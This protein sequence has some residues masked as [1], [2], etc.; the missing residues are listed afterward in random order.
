MIATTLRSWRKRISASNAPTP[1]DGSVDR[2][3]I[4]WIKLSYKTPS[5]MYTV[6]SAARISNG[7]LDSEF[8]KDAAVP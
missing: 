6:T 7:S 8:V 1:A 4:G 2:I 5:T 3:V